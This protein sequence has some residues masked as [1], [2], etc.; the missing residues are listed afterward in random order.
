MLVAGSLYIEHLQQFL[1]QMYSG[2]ALQ[3]QSI[4][5]HTYRLS[6]DTLSV[7]FLDISVHLSPYEWS[8]V[9]KF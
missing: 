9:R 8:H 3:M 7:L 6:E 4:E 1:V 5:A 2:T